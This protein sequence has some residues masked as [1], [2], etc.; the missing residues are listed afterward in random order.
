MGNY[1]QSWVFVGS[2]KISRGRFKFLDTDS[3]SAISQN[4]LAQKEKQWA[5]CECPSH[6]QDNDTKDACEKFK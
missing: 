6:S 5:C 3:K 4:K 2:K 1:S